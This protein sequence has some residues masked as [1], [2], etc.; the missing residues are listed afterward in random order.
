M[1]QAWAD[2]LVELTASG[3]VVAGSSA[4][5]SRTGTV[6]GQMPADGDA[7]RI[8]RRNVNGDTGRTSE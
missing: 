4:Q 8:P 2:Y 7:H 6:D 3:G 1:M 5:A